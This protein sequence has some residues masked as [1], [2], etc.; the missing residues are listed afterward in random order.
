MIAQ[1]MHTQLAESSLLEHDAGSRAWL[2][3]FPPPRRSAIANWFHAAVRAGHTTPAAVVHQVHQTIQ[4][5]LQW[6]SDPTEDAHFQSVLQALWTNRV[7]ALTYAE[8]VIAWE[9]LPYDERLRH[10]LTA[11]GKAPY[12]TPPLCP[13]SPADHQTP[14]PE[15]VFPLVVWLRCLTCQRGYF[16]AGAPGP[17][18]C[19][20]CSGGRLQPVA[21]WDLRTNPAP[22]GMLRVAP[23]AFVHGFEVQR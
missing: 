3:R 14:P 1:Q 19:P 9:R 6:V 12:D 10:L 17:E 18:P 8:T 2:E 20:A 7:G 11:K 23:V 4:R 22:P 13:G 5:R 15:H 16:A 21:L